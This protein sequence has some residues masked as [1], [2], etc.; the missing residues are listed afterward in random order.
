MHC[1]QKPW[2][3]RPQLLVTSLFS[4]D[5]YDENGS[6]EYSNLLPQFTKFSKEEYYKELFC[7]FIGE[8]RMINIPNYGQVLQNDFSRQ[9]EI[10]ETLNPEP[11]DNNAQK[12]KL[13]S[14]ENWIDLNEDLDILENLGKEIK[15]QIEPSQNMYTDL[16]MGINHRNI[17]R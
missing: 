3:S 2:P 11:F 6:D 4:K 1:V 10:I 14:W 16:M 15:S 7:L 12:A 13:S 5:L 9:I 8:R 17:Y